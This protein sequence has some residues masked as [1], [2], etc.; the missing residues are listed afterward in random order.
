[1][2]HRRIVSLTA[3]VLSLGL[4]GAG[5]ATAAAP[6]APA[7]VAPTATTPGSFAPTM[8][9][10]GPMSTP[11]QHSGLDLAEIAARPPVTQVTTVGKV[12][13]GRTVAAEVG[14]LRAYVLPPGNQGN[15]QSCVAWALGYSAYGI[16]M[17]KAGRPGA[18][19]APMYVYSQV[20][21]GVDQGS[22]APRS[23]SVL[24]EQGIDTREHYSHGDHDWSSRPTQEDRSN[25]ANYKLS[26]YRQIPLRPSMAIPAIKAAINNGYP[27]L[28]GMRLRQNFVDM[29]AETAR[30][31]TYTASGDVI[32]G[33]ELAVVAYD[34]KGMTLQNTWGTAWGDGGYLTLPWSFLGA[35]DVVEIY[36]MGPLEPVRGPSLAPVGTPSPAPTRM[37]TSVPAVS[38][39]TAR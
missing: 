30:S 4:A 39:R 29:D 8:I 37:P 21:N 22:S 15:V 11:R 31:Y 7:P 32:G 6:P 25:A 16:L 36:S 20:N 9:H 23:F 24:M 38:A 5:P 19:M 12:P 26:G 14:D 1:M 34:E 17:N 10:A 35:G 27:A 33:H 18:P 3:L 28:I 13:M 2:H